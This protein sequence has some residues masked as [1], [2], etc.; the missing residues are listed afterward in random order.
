[1]PSPRRYRLV[2][3]L[4]L[5]VLGG[6]VAPPCKPAHERAPR[7]PVGWCCLQALNVDSTE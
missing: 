7:A 3:G 2:V 4:L 5:L 1:M 6:C